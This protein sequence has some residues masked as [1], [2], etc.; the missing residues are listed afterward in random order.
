M[1][2]TGLDEGAIDWGEVEA[3]ET[4][5]TTGAATIRAVQ[6][7]PV[8]MRLV[9]YS[10]GYLAD[11]WCAKGHVI[12]V[13]AGALD[14]EHEDGSP[15]IALTPGMTWHCADETAPAHRVRTDGPATVFIVD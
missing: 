12:L 6:A 9:A 1:K 15:A 7:G 3:T 2:L 11:H 10:P 13:L 8:Q 4:K 5:G 14:I